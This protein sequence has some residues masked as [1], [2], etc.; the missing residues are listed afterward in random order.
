MQGHHHPFHEMIVPVHGLIRVRIHER[1]H[2]CAPGTVL[3]YP[4][5][6][7]HEEWSDAD[8]ALESYFVAFH[9]PA[10]P[11][12]DLVTS[13]DPDGRIRQILRW[14]HQDQRALTGGGDTIQQQ[15]LHLLIALFKQGRQ[16]N[17][18]EW[19]QKAR[20]YARHHLD[21]PICLD[22]LARAAG[23]SR[24]HFLREYRRHTG[25]TP[26]ADVRQIRADYARSLILTTSMPLKEI[27]P[28]AGFANEYTLSRTFRQLFNMPPGAFRCRR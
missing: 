20:K 23:V 19:V 3:F 16:P 14:M 12:D 25:R 11:S 18:N 27:A 28:A 8:K 7:T 22:D 17:E 15:Y 5:G 10:L 9:S 24:F 6:V 13:E 4:A 1:E 26:I 2:T 21:D